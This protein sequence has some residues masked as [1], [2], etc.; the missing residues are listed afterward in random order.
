MGDRI[1]IG[2][3]TF[4]IG[5]QVGLVQ[6]KPKLDGDLAKEFNFFGFPRS[7]GAAVMGGEKADELAIAQDGNDDIGLDLDAL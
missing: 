2:A 4:G 6:G 3:G 5:Q 1:G 7:G